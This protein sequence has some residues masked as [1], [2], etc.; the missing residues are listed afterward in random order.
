MVD[1]STDHESETHDFEAETTPYARVRFD[2]QRAGRSVFSEDEVIGAE[3]IVNASTANF[4][5]YYGWSC[6]LTGRHTWTMVATDDYGNRL[7]RKGSFDVGRCYTRRDVVRRPQVIRYIDSEFRPDQFVTRIDCR[8]TPKGDGRA[9]AHTCFVRWNNARRECE[10][11]Y[12]FRR[13]TQMRFGRAINQYFGTRQ[14]SRR[15]C[16]QYDPR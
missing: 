3:S 12:T 11:T 4:A 1:V 14:R 8:P 2:I 7:E 15:R 6:R 9:H 16:R 5:Y 13:F 10:A